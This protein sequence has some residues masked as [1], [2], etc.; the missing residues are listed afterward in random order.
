MLLPIFLASL[1]AW[2]LIVRISVR[3][4]NLSLWRSTLKRLRNNPQKLSD[5][6]GSKTGKSCLST[7]AGAVAKR[8]CELPESATR[9]D[10][11]N[12]VDEVMKW[13]IPILEKEI[14]M[15]GAIAAIA[16]LLGLL[17]T[18]SGMIHTFD[19]ISAFGTSNPSLM[20]DSI[21]EA[22]VT[23]QDGL[24]VALPLMVI[25][26]VLS[27]YA[28]R[29]EDSALELSQV[30]IQFRLGTARRLVA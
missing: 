8:L 26:M 25:H 30:Y 7:V 15:V 21:S 4:W 27:N 2:I 18:V 16:P 9:E 6:V 10:M 5:W 19:V 23:T 13:H 17:G 22:L 3:L 11:E 12:G 1:W 24:V 28:R 20:A 14:S 29:I